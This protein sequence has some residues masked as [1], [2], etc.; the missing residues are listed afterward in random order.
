MF[1]FFFRGGR[2]GVWKREEREEDVYVKKK[3]KKY[4]LVGT[5]DWESRWYC[6]FGDWDR[7]RER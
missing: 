6:F 4:R 2:E 1:L 5:R 7:E 3:K